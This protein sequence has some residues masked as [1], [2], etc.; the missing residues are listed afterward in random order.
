[1][2]RNAA[3]GTPVLP[4]GPPCLARWDFPFGTLQFSL[5]AGFEHPWD[6][7]APL[8]G[9]SEERG[10]G[11]VL[12]PQGAEVLVILKSWLA[13]PSAPKHLFPYSPGWL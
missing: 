6:P 7:H 11:R 12:L 13:L 5:S 3:L 2:V 9:G 10:A 1:M 8:P 4:W